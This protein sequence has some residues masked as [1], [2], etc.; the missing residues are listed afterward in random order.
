MTLLPKLI[1][2]G[3][4][5]GSNQDWQQRQSLVNEF[6]EPALDAYLTALGYR[7]LQEVMK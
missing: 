6:I 4:F 7:S 1:E 3:R 2:V 5:D